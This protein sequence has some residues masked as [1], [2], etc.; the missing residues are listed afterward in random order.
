MIGTLRVLVVQNESGADR[1][2]QN[3]RR[4]GY[5]VETADTGAKALRSHHSVDLVIL[6]LGLPD[7][8]GVELCRRIRA[9]S[10]V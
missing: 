10:N 2:V 4:N 7:L 5:A 6:E 3:L 9:I 8:D 1:L